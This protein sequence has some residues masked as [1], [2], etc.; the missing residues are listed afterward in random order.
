MMEHFEGPDSAQN[1][2]VFVIQTFYLSTASFYT[3]GGLL[4]IISSSR[5]VSL[6]LNYLKWRYGHRYFSGGVHG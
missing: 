1:L 2:Q 4:E 6:S 5:L 3:A